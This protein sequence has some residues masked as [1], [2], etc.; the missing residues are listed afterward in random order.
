ML[1]L[2]RPIQVMLTSNVNSKG[3]STKIFLQDTKIQN[4]TFLT[5][6]SKFCFILKF[7]IQRCINNVFSIHYFLRLT[8]SEVPTYKRICAFDGINRALSESKWPFFIFHH[9]GFKTLRGYKRK[10]FNEKSNI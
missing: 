2:L 4:K 3:P 9:S 1:T 6:V 5:S 10:E 8:R 7:V